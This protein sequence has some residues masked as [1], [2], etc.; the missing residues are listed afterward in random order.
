MAFLHGGYTSIR[1]P[2]DEQNM[3]K[4]YTPN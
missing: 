1:A 2:K 4:T 3:N